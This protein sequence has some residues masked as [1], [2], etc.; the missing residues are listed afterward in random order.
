MFRQAAFDLWEK[1][2]KNSFSL[3]PAELHPRVWADDLVSLFGEALP[4][5]RGHHL[6]ANIK[7][8]I[9]TTFL[10]DC[11]SVNLYNRSNSWIIF[12]TSNLL[13]WGQLARRYILLWW[14]R[15]F[16]NGLVRIRFCLKKTVSETLQ[17][18][19]SNWGM[20]INDIYLTASSDNAY[21]FASTDIRYGTFVIKPTMT[22]KDHF[23]NRCMR[24]KQIHLFL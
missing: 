14:I 8:L 6:L 22:L 13:I 20:P 19:P 1:V 11:S 18:D 10:Y 12:G 3:L 9:S 7:Y 15:S 16:I 24:K 5:Q 4:Q 23:R 17:V 2:Q 21:L